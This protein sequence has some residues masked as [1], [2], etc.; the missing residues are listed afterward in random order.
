MDPAQ[1]D[2]YLHR[3]GAGRPARP[4]VGVLREPGADRAGH[5]PDGVTDRRTDGLTD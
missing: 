2:A 5:R 1:A 3:L 4:A